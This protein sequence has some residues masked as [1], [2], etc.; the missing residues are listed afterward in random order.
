MDKSKLTDLIKHSSRKGMYE[1]LY[2][3]YSEY[4]DKLSLKTAAALISDELGIKVTLNTIR[5]LK[6]AKQTKSSTNWESEK[7]NSGLAIVDKS[8]TTK[9]SD[10]MAKKLQYLDK[11]K[12]L[13]IF[14]AKEVQPK[15]GYKPL[16]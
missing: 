4:I 15:S 5:R 3:H 1:L 8:D 13:D 2:L 16:E 9:Q 10:S 14:A 11:Y 7:L 12:P 6:I